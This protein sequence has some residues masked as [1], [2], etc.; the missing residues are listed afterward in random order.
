MAKDTGKL[1]KQT[2]ALIKAATSRPNSKKS[3][4]KKK[5]NGSEKKSSGPIVKILKGLEKGVGVIAK[6]RDRDREKKLLEL[7]KSTVPRL[8]QK[9]GGGARRGFAK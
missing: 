9:S 2:Q 3:D 5:K 8:D 7:K 1:I 4:E 6:Q